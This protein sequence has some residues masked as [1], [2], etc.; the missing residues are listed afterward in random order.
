MNKEACTFSLK[1]NTLQ[2][3]T[4]LSL[5]MQCELWSLVQENDSLL[6]WP[7]SGRLS[8]HLS[9]HSMQQSIEGLS[10]F[11]EILKD[12]LFPIP[13][14]AHITLPTEGSEFMSPLHGLPF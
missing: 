6:L 13:K 10:R 11:Q 14:T 4:L 8:L 1:K 7:D 12:H 5:L 3:P 9:Q 2:T